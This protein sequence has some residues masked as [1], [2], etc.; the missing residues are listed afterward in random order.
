[1]IAFEV[2]EFSLV[3]S[4]IPIGLALPIILQRKLLRRMSPERRAQAWPEDEQLTRTYLV[5]NMP[6]FG[7]LSMIPFCVVTR[8]RR[9][10]VPMALAILQGIGWSLSLVGALFLYGVAYGLVL[11]LLDPRLMPVLMGS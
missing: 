11:E 1:M 5:S 9:G 8:P 6:L 3:V 4:T 2:L 10:A 7:L